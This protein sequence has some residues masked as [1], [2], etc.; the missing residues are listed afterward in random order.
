MWV[1]GG[2]RVSSIRV[3]VMVTVRV[4]SVVELEPLNAYSHR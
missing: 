1:R 4:R 2:V 3:G